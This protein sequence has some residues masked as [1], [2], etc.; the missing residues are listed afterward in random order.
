MTNRKDEWEDLGDRLK[1]AREFRGYSQQQIAEILDIS[2]TAVSQI[3][4]GER[5]IDSI[6]LQQLAD[7]YNTSIDKLVGESSDD[8]NIEEIELL[9]RATKELSSEDRKEVLRFAEFLRSKDPENQA[10]D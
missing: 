9:T 10:D 7:F 5:K 4:N 8:E 2:R 6:E 1:K 3:E